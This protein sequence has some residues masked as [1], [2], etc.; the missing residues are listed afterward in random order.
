M[1]TLERGTYYKSPAR[2]QRME[3]AQREEA[4]LKALFERKH[5]AE[6]LGLMY[7]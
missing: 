2:F 7:R 1:D 6:I 3:A 4:A 5:F